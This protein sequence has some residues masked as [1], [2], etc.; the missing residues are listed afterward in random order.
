MISF[1]EGMVAGV[2]EGGVVLNVGGVGF[3]VQTPSE[4]VSRLSTLDKDETVRLHTY[5]YIREDAMNLYGFVTR[6]E[7]EL[8]KKLISVSGI[9]PKGGL[10]LL[11]VMSADDLRFAIISGDSK[12]ISRAPGIGKKTAERLVIDLRDKLEIKTYEDLEDGGFAAADLSGG[13]HAAEDAAGE[14]AIE[15]LTALGYL[16]TEAAKAVKQAR[17]DGNEDTESLLKGALRYLG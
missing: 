3:F 13:A 2:E 9:G 6:D 12:S 16:R 11:S 8:F 5:M 7:L 14:D 4:T 1:V 10:A 17:A 15:A